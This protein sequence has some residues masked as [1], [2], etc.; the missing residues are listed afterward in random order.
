MK[1]L[2]RTLSVYRNLAVVLLI[3]LGSRLDSCA[4]EPG[5]TTLVATNA[6]WRFH[7][8]GA[9]LGTNWLY[10]GTDD[11]AWGLGVAELG[12][13]DGDEASM[14]NFGPDA[15][16]KYIT[17][18][19]RHEFI[20]PSP[21][22]FTSLRMRVKFD[23][24]LV[25]Y[26]NGAEVYRNDLAPGQNYLSLAPVASDDDTNYLTV[27]ISPSLLLPDRNILAAEMHLATPSDPD[28]SYDLELVGL[29]A[30]NT[31]AP[32]LTGTKVNASQWVV[33]WPASVSSNFVL[34][35]S[36]LLRPA[37]WIT[38]SNSVVVAGGRYNV[39]NVL[40]PSTKFFRLY[41]ATANTVPCQ[42]PLVLTQ[43]LEIF[44]GI[45]TNLSL[46]LSVTG[47]PPVAYQWFHNTFPVTNATTPTLTLTN[48]QRT[49]GG[50]YEL[51]MSGPCDTERS[52]PISVT[53][54]GIDGAMT[55]NFASRPVFTDISGDINSSNQLATA[56]AGEPAILGH[57]AE[58]SVWLNYVAPTDGVIT[59]TTVGSTFDTLLAA[60][61]G[62]SVSA[63][64]LIDADDDQGPAYT[65]LISFAVTNG[66]PVEVKVDNYPGSAGDFQLGW[67]LVP[68]NAVMPLII[69]QPLSQL[70]VISNNFTVSV[71][72]TNPGSLVPLTYQ[73]R[74]N[75]T[76][77]IGATNAA[78]TI[79]NA[80]AA[81]TGL[82]DVRVSNGNFT[83][84]SQTANIAALVGTGQLITVTGGAKRTYCTN[85]L[86]YANYPFPSGTVSLTPPFRLNTV[87]TATGN[88]VTYQIQATRASTLTTWCTTSGVPVDPTYGGGPYLYQFVILVPTVP[89]TL[90]VSTQ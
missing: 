59:F 6:C 10:S 53:V 28:I 13:G 90:N 44:A 61:H 31:A 29:Y 25:I 84:T 18:Y 57:P 19:F 41:W 40:T 46:S 62:T 52:Y 33:S 74:H 89:V 21:T 50:R 80:Q 68:T 73:W 66:E 82:Y 71:V 49:D 75:G 67:N 56:E 14:L 11:S 69:V 79:L 55:D 1:F 7:D 27:I 15:S 39:T 23:D 78:L 30:T 36:S 37:N 12:Y 42:P 70:V 35:S 4:L 5:V 88:A 34:Q 26:L 54:G 85:Y 76:N 83:K 63:L 86:Y 48:V 32:I 60:Y 24:G 38:V 9:D 47:T 77:V 17:T 81:S 45:G 51:N 65:S 2:T 72:A 8:Q 22:A 3:L 64:N 16:N 58:R 43:P 20:V 87:N